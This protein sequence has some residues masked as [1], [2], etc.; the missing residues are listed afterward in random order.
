MDGLAD[1]QEVELDTPFGKPSDAYI[2]GVLAGVPVVFLARHSRGHTIMPS[3]LNFKANIHGLKQLSVERI[4]SISAVGS[5]REDIAPRDIVLV[6]QFVDRTKASGRH[7]FFGD[8]VV[9][10]IAF[11]DPVCPDVRQIALAACREELANA[12]DGM[13]GRPPR[14]VDGGTYL[15]MEGPAFSTRAESDLYRSWGM[16]V[17]GMTN[18]AEAKL[19]REAQICYATMA[20]A[21]DYDCWHPDHDS[22]TVDTIIRTLTQNATAAKNIIRRA[23]PRLAQG[24]PCSCATALQNALLTPY[25]SMP[26]RTRE[27]LSLLLSK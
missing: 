25:D 19:A 22:V 24:R 23:V 26:E 4:L 13:A 5:L 10:H 27:K 15:N 2:T 14:A 16:D 3:E 20:M 17:V 12:E 9:A 11:G 18:V 7:S 1:V 6:D 8:G 21:T